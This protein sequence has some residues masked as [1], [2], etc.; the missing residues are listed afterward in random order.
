MDKTKNV[1]R[2]CGTIRQDEL[3]GKED[4]LWVVFNLGVNR[5]TRYYIH[6]DIIY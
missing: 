2:P 6:S 5:N 4:D 3:L 1:I